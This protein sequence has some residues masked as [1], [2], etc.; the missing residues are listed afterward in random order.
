MDVDF[1]SIDVYVNISYDVI[2]AAHKTSSKKDKAAEILQASVRLNAKFEDG[3]F[4]NDKNHQLELIKII[5]DYRPKIVI[6]NAPTDRHPDHG[7]GS[8]LV[9]DSCFLSG[10]EKIQTELD[11]KD[12]KAW[13]PNCVYHY[14][15]YRNQ[16]PDIVV[17]VSD[18]YEIKMDAVKAHKS[19][20]YDATSTESETLISRPEFLEYIKGNAMD[21]GKQI[22]V[23]YAEGFTVDRYIGTKDLLTLI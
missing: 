15:Q 11:G 22:G 13:R 19:Q 17:D 18:F 20:F 5:R 9:A 8:Q 1:S 12:Q 7:R 21:M 3:F 16:K 23:R 14:I 10:L 2:G 6:A 4:L